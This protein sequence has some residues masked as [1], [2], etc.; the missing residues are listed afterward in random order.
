[1]PKLNEHY[2]DL[3]ESYLFAEIA[4]RVAAYEAE[5]PDSKIIR[6][7]IGDV[8]LPLGDLTIKGLHEGVD[9]MASAETFKGYGPEQGY[10]FLRDAIS[11]Y[12]ARNGVSVDAADI[13]ISDG[14]KSDTGNISELFDNDNV[15]LIPDPVYPVYVDSNIMNGKNVTYLSGNAENNFLPMPDPSVHAD[16]IYL[17]SPN[18]PTGAVYNKEQ[19][20]EWVDYAL[21]NNAVI[22][23]D[24]A[25]E[26]FISDPELP[27]SI[28]AIE[29]A[30]KCAIEF[31][32]LS[33]TAGFTG[34]RCGYTVVPRELVFTASNGQEMSLHAMWNRRQSTKFN[35]TSYIIQKGAAAVFT[36]EGMAQ[37]RENIAY[38]QE[39]ARIIAD[40]LKRRNIRFFGGVHSPY[41]WFE[42]P[43]GMESWEFF[44]YL[45]NNAQVVGTP[46]AGFGENGKNYFRLTSFNNHENT[47][48]AMKRFEHLF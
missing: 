47:I 35:G 32:S 19:L 37:C 36:E 13:F 24:S 18:N 38:Y 28:Y 10:G 17:C 3:K 34:T 46:G 14:A 21:A 12:Y 29:G 1:M 41:I 9:A 22:L 8:T 20:K 27:R 45:L 6:L 39:N 43:D 42:C 26:A 31:C 2:Q 40:T 16:I 44:D 7:G 11:A 33:K 4:H 5:H 25:Y 23:F 48:A 15:I 30:K